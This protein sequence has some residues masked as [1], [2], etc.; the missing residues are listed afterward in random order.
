MK[1]TFESRMYYKPPSYY[2]LCTNLLKQSKV[3]VSK[4][5]TKRM[6]NLIHKY[7]TTICFDGWDNIA[8]HPLLNVILAC[9]NGDVFISSIDTTG[10]QKN[11][12]YICN[13]L[14]RGSKQNKV[15]QKSKRLH[16]NLVPLI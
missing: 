5:V 11:A 16:F 7:G 6:Q 15:Y 12:H 1:T 14:T 8:Q 10:E 2:G 13:V 4:Q 9:L 3:D